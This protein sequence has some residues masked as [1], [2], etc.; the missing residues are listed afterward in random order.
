MEYGLRELK[1]EKRDDGWWDWFSNV[2]CLEVW[3]ILNIKMKKKWIWL[4][5]ILVFRK[6]KLVCK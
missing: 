4:L 2:N 1:I 3:S 5:I 6:K